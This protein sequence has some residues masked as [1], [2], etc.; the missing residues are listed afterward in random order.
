MNRRISFPEG[1]LWGS[2]QSAYQ[3]EGH[4]YNNDW[5]EFEQIPGVIKNGDKCGESSDHYNLYESDFKLLS[6][7]NQNAL[8]TGIEWS[9]I[10]PEE[11]VVNEDELEH[12]HKVIASL[13]KNNLTEFIN[14]HHFTIP[15]WF[16]RK[17][18]FLKTKNLKYFEHYCEILAK[19]FPEVEFWNTINEPGVVPLMGYLY[20]EFPPRKKSFLAFG[21]IYRNMLRAHALAYHK[22]KEFNPKSQVG[23]VKTMPYFYQKYNSKLWKKWVVSV[24]D[25]AYNQVMFN[26]LNRGKLPLLPF[27]YDKI[28]KD[29]SDFF[30]LNYYDPVIFKFKLGFPTSMDFKLPDQTETTQM[31]WGI[32]PQG[33]YED[34][35]RVKQEFKGPIYVT[36][37]GIATL[38]DEQRQKF[39]IAHLVE[40]HKAISEG[41]DVRGF[42]Y[43]SSL[44]N[45]EWAEGFEPRFG[46]IGIDYE[47]KKRQVRDSARMYG[48]IAKENSISEDL[49]KKHG[50][51]MK[52]N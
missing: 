11:N 40:V 28:L 41:A 5:Y 22:I 8:R 10:V 31:G 18:G 37:N 52:Q 47:T 6:G 15:I 34:I 29:S 51:K 33:L 3:V 2:A 44:D 48:N 46:L 9:R 17:G 39:I 36:E 1:F 12:Y 38:Q 24:M 43:W 50:I 21:K 23:I 32:Y 45:W 49:L 16:E 7:L 19:S 4:N 30:G 26:A 25:F 14:I 35:M 42:F 20:G 13:K 27:G